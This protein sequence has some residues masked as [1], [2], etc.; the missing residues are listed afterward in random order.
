M[1]VT[2]LARAVVA[3]VFSALALASYLACGV[4]KSAPRSCQADCGVTE[5]CC[6]G[7]Y[8]ITA[9]DEA[10]ITRTTQSNGDVC[11]SMDASAYTPNQSIECDGEL[12]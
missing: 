4:A 12:L 6:L 2:M 7:P 5:N 1:K 11:L 9:P 3:V 10:G 8:K